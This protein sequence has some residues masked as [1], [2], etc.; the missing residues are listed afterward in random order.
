MAGIGLGSSSSYMNDDFFDNDV[1]DENSLENP[2]EE[3]KDISNKND[4]HKSDS[5]LLGSQMTKLMIMI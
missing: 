1:D 5:L 4:L 2:F 3:H